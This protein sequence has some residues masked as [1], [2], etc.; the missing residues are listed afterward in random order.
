MFRLCVDRPQLQL[1][2][3]QVTGRP[4][5]RG[6]QQGG[7]TLSLALGS[8]SRHVGMVNVAMCDASV[9]SIADGID[10][11]IWRAMSTMQGGEHNDTDLE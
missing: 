2:C 3:N 8:R 4:R 10:P 7:Q 11:A 9:R 6:R 1:P 5:G